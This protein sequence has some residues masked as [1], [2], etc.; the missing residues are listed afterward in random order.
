MEVIVVFYAGSQFASSA[1]TNAS[2]YIVDRIEKRDEV[3]TDRIGSDSFSKNATCCIGDYGSI[4]SSLHVRRLHIRIIRQRHN[5]VPLMEKSFAR[6]WSRAGVACPGHNHV[7]EA[8]KL[9]LRGGEI[10]TGVGELRN[11]LVT[12]PV[13]RFYRNSK[14]QRYW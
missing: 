12:Q 10:A 5:I 2:S 14:R 1:F 6:R 11:F 3:L 4:R 7:S 8:S 9:V 13:I